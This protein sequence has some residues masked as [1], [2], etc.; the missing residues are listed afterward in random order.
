MVLLW[1]F[2]VLAAKGMDM[3]VN[4]RLKNIYND[5]ITIVVVN[6]IMGKSFKNLCLSIRQGDRPSSIAAI[7]LSGRSGG[8]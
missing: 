1:V 5:N 2:K 3:S 7:S 4:E 8:D 6:N